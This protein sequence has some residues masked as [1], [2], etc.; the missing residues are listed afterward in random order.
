MFPWLVDEVN[1]TGAWS[2]DP[3]PS[4]RPTVV[5]SQNPLF[6]DYKNVLLT[7]MMYLYA[8]DIERR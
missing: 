5:K 8:F 1:W 6:S 2:R 7:L 3:G 4:I